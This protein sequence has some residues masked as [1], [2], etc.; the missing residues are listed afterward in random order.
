MY[1]K[2]A[3]KLAADAGHGFIAYPGAVDSL[4]DT[5]QDKGNLYLDR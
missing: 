5:R 2:T 1:C 3:L 4:I